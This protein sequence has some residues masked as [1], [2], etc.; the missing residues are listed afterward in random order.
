[1]STPPIRDVIEAAGGAAPLAAACGVDR[2]TVYSWRRI[3]AQH[4]AAAARVTGWAAAQLRPD[5]AAVF[6]PGGPAPAAPPEA[7]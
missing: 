3:P 2:T 1:M 7:A 4:L 5:L 6:G